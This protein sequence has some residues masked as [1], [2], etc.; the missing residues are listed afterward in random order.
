MQGHRERKEEDVSVE[1][2]TPLWPHIEPDF[3][4]LLKVVHRDSL[5]DRVPFIELFA[6]GEIVGAVVGE[7]PV[8]LFT[9]LTNREAQEAS[10]RQRIRFCQTVGYD[11]VWAATYSPLMLMIPWLAADDTAQLN[12][13]ARTWVNEADGIIHS[14]ADLE[15]LDWPT[16]EAVDYSEM[17]FVCQNVPEGMK[18]VAETAGILELVMWLMGY[19]SFAVALYDDPELVEALFERVGDLMAAIYDTMCDYPNVGLAFLGDDMGHRTGTMVHPD[20][21]RQYVFPR[22]RRLAEIT[23]AHGL[24]FLLH[25]CGDLRAVMDDLIDDVGIDGKHSFEDSYLPVTEAKRLYGRRTSVLGGV[26][27]DFLVRSSEEEVRAYTRRVLEACMPGGG[28]ALGTGNSVANYIPVR[29][30]LAMLDEGVK[31]GVYRP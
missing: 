7:K 18:V 9:A 26:D 28:Y 17:D 3:E 30:Y 16:P 10:L 15:A 31:V 23:H 13:G 4:R 25:S 11:F 24:P 21:L 6:D 12:R 14:M 2:A 19:A 1:K 8:D 27:M 20:H 29:N 5:P 22:Q